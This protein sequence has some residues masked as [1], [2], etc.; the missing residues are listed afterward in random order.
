V[1]VGPIQTV[2]RGTAEVTEI[3]EVGKR[4][5]IR[6]RGKETQG[7]GTAEANV[8][9]TLREEDGETLVTVLSQIDVT[10]GPAQFGRG[11]MADVGEQ[12]IS[13][14]AKRLQTLLEGDEVSGQPSVGIDGVPTRTANGSMGGSQEEAAGNDALDLIALVG[15]AAI[16]RVVPLAVGLAV[17]LG[18]IWWFTRQ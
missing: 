4:A 12:I 18:L 6:A 13:Q 11:I 10:G 1:K 8:T 9:V 16:K 7:T 15:P 17:I 14:F 2:Y 3:D 5:S